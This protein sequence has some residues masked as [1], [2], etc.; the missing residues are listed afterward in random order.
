MKR[1]D[2]DGSISSPRQLRSG[3]A[4]AIVAKLALLAALYVLFFSAS[5]RPSVD[6]ADVVQRLHPSR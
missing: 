3:V 1:P 4:I 2:A 6:A 5:H